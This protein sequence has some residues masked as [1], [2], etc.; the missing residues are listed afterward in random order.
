MVRVGYEG[1]MET[2]FKSIPVLMQIDIP[3]RIGYWNWPLKGLLLAVISFFPV[4]KLNK[5]SFMDVIPHAVVIFVINGSKGKGIFESSDGIFDIISCWI[6]VFHH[7]SCDL[8]S[9]LIYLKEYFYL[10]WGQRGESWWQIR[11]R[12]CLSLLSVRQRSQPCTF[13]WFLRCISPSYQIRPDWSDW[14]FV[15]ELLRNR[16]QTFP[17][18]NSP[19]FLSFL[20]KCVSPATD[21]SCVC[22][23]LIHTLSWISRRFDPNGSLSRN[24][25]C[26]CWGLTSCCDFGAAYVP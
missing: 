19:L 14:Q 1:S 6:E 22:I 15:C 16:S 5:N 13:P 23:V 12:R 24:Q 10:S 21:H 9:I 8:F 11:T 20:L 25:S 7:Y 2:L 3:L 4:T 26:Y 18:H 17:E